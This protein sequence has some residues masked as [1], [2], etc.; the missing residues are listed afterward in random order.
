MEDVKG[1]VNKAKKGDTEAFGALYEMYATELYRFAV[2]Y[3]NSPTAAQ[4][5]VQDTV[6]EAFKGIPKLKSPDKFKAWLFRIHSNVC[7]QHLR[8]VYISSDTVSLENYLSPADDAP[9]LSLALEVN[10]ALNALDKD[11][12]EIV[13][14]SV[15]CGC[16]G[17]E[18]AEM[19]DCPQ[20]TVRSKLSR[21]LEKLRL[22]LGKD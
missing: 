7:K 18:I 17:K 22:I 16:T 11:D 3:L 21:S 12:R 9:P 10:G 19:L 5:A 15:V 2:Y 1:L 14:L 13:L 4:D 20:G 6:L 8:S